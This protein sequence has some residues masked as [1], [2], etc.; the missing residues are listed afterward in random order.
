VL[1]TP[2]KSP[3][4]PRPNAGRACEVEGRLFFKTNLCLEGN[5]KHEA[6]VNPTGF[7]R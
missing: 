7:L 2:D 1:S 3:L 4:T 5:V 6:G